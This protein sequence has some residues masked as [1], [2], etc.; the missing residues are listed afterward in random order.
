MTIVGDSL[1]EPF[2]PEGTGCG[3]GVLSCLDAAWLFKQW[4][5]ARANPLEILTE[6]E[7]IYRLLSQTSDGA[8]L[9]KDGY[10]SF[11]INPAT[12]EAIHQF[13]RIILNSDS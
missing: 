9:L 2:W 5:L 10:K 8:G 1:L 12:R 13:S 4:C 7:N 3:R 6:R 11:T